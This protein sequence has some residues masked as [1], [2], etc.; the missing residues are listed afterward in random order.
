MTFL[1]MIRRWW[2][3]RRRI[4][5]S[6]NWYQSSLMTNK[7]KNRNKNRRNV[8][9]R[10]DKFSSRD[11]QAFFSILVLSSLISFA[12]PRSSSRLS[13]IVILISHSYHPTDFA[14]VILTFFLHCV[15][16][17]HP[18]HNLKNYSNL[19]T[20]YVMCLWA[21]PSV[22]STQHQAGEWECG[23]NIKLTLL[24]LPKGKKKKLI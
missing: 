8:K 11:Y 5:R 23:K 9:N 4:S 22:S 15:C 3:P 16:C 6:N 18:R 10:W 1:L 13:L 14:V 24:L 7:L 12:I 17:L 2:V 20:E 19:H 21:S